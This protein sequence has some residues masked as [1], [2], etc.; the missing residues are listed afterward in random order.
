MSGAS[1]STRRAYRS[2]PDRLVA[3]AC[4]AAKIS[5][6]MLRAMRAVP[7]TRGKAATDKDLVDQVRESATAWVEDADLVILCAPLGA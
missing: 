7:E 5:A 6:A 3:S 1:L 4:C 2:R